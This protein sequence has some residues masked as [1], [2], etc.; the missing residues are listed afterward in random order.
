MLLEVDAGFMVKLV[1]VLNP[2][3]EDNAMVSARFTGNLGELCVKLKGMTASQCKQ[4]YSQLGS[5]LA[6]VSDS[7]F[8]SIGNAILTAVKGRNKDAGPLGGGDVP[9]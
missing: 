5:F 9:S 8:A 1:C 4:I 6:E 7:K 3:V 2:A